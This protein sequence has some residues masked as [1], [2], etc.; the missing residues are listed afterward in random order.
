MMN[1]R[2]VA[3]GLLLL[4]GILPTMACA[5]PSISNYHLMQSIGELGN[6][7]G[8]V[9]ILMG[10]SLV[11]AGIFKL[12]RYG[13]MRTMMSHQMTI[14]QPMMMLVSG[15]VLLALPLAIRT[16]LLAFWSTSSPLAYHAQSATDALFIPPILMFV[17]LIGVIAFI[18]GWILIS[19][20]G[21]NGQPG[22]FAKGLIHIISG[23]LAIHI[24]GVVQ[25]LK[26]IFSI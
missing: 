6:I 14:A 11:F 1:R 20:S 26:S 18:R 2:Y 13:E 16:I 17:R 23:I 8:T 7:I 15:A 21:P 3:T 22:T 12:K 9:A 10:V 25:I 4:I 5:S 24:L 19:R